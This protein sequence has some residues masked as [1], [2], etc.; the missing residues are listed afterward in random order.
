V[1]AICLM[2]IAPQLQAIG[3]ELEKGEAD[4]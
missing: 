2:T 4:E 1:S 3:S